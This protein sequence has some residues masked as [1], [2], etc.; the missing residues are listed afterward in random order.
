LITEP[1]WTWLDVYRYYAE[2]LNLPLELAAARDNRPATSGGASPS[3]FVRRTLGYFANTNVLRERLTFLLAF[4]PKSWN[5][6]TY[7]RYLQSRAQHEIQSLKDSN[8]MELHVPE[9]REMKVL[10]FPDLGDPTALIAK[11]PLRCKFGHADPVRPA[12]EE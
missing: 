11:Y 8:R 5:E 10:G 2:Q 1:Q 3:R 12:E 9:W 6:R 4:L 7:M